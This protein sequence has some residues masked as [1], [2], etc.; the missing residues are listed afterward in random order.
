MTSRSLITYVAWLAV[1]AGASMAVAQATSLPSAGDVDESLFRDGLRQR[2]LTEWLDQYFADT[3][4]VDE[5]DARLRQREQLLEE[6]TAADLTVNQ[7][8]TLVNR[9]GAILS[10]LITEHP[11]HPARLRWQLELPRSARTPRSPGVQRPAAVR[12]PRARPTGRR[13]TERPRGRDARDASARDRPGLAGARNPR[14]GGD[15][16]GDFV[17][18][19]ARS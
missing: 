7:R 5:A 15:R 1:P 11:E 16:A 14:R 13:R 19:A 9:A 2:G 18:L 6:A 8:R 3:P 12:S 10:S 17:W 4:P